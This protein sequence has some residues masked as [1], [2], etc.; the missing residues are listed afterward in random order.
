MNEFVVNLVSNIEIGNVFDNGILI[1]KHC[2]PLINYDISHLKL[3]KNVLWHKIF[4]NFFSIF[5]EKFKVSIFEHVNSLIFMV[6]PIVT[7]HS[8]L[9]WTYDHK[10]LKCFSWFKKFV[11]RTFR[12]EFLQKSMFFI[13]IGIP[14]KWQFSWNFDFFICIIWMSSFKYEFLHTKIHYF[15]VKKHF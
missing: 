3:S 1:F 15:D 14:W 12:Y 11:G 4:L 8:I 5:D 2:W 10:Y 13:H 9:L 6:F 7:N